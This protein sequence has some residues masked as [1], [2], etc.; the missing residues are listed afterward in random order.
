MTK[1]YQKTL[2]K[3]LQFLAIIIPIIELFVAIFAFDIPKERFDYWSTTVLLCELLIC[4][5]AFYKED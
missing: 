2:K 3:D 5:M 4:F 1:K